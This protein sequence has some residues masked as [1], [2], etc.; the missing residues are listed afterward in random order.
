MAPRPVRCAW[1]ETGGRVGGWLTVEAD[2]VDAE[3][4]TGRRRGTL[5]ST[6]VALVEQYV[7]RVNAAI[8]GGA[9]AEIDAIKAEALNSALTL[10]DQ[11]PDR[12]VDQ[13]AAVTLVM[14]YIR[15]IELLHHLSVRAEGRNE[16]LRL[17]RSTSGPAYRNDKPSDRAKDRTPTP[18][19]FYAEHRKVFGHQR[20]GRVEAP[21]NAAASPDQIANV[22]RTHGGALSRQIHHGMEMLRE[23]L[24]DLGFEAGNLG[25]IFS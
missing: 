2:L 11:V 17:S 12:V 15:T 22:F 23:R 6:L 24:A 20:K 16:C 7:R 8:D 21:D 19:C 18:Y 4:R 25:Q 14:D 9:V 13:V 10:Y 5:A 3:G 1:V